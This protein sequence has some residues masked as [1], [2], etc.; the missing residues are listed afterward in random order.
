MG[1]CPNERVGHYSRANNAIMWAGT[2]H[3]LN[4]F[5]KSH[6]SDERPDRSSSGNAWKECK[7]RRGTT[8]VSMESLC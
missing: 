1:S 4:Q 7:V 8:L 3:T 2:T 6:Y 5:V